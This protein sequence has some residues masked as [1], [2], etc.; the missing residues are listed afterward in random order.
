MEA[1]VVFCRSRKPADRRGKVLLIDAVNEVARERAVS[2]LRPEHQ[3]RIAGAYSAFADQEGFAAV[4][5][6]AEIAAQGHSLSIPLYVKRPAA[7]AGGEGGGQPATLQDAWETWEA[8]GQEF[9][10]QMDGVV[11]MLDGLVAE[12]SLTDSVKEN[13]E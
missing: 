8:S 7:A 3:A 12:V 2:F 6:L 4:A 10:Q 9:W 13:Q 11:A 5:T 1:C